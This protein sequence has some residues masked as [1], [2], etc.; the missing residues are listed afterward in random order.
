M[1]NSLNS[2]LVHADAG[3][4]S[5][6][7][8]HP[9]ALPIAV[10]STYIQPVP[11]DLAPFI[12]AE[13]AAMAAPA[14][15]EVKSFE[16]VYSRD[17]SPTT[18]RV[19]AVMGALEGAYPGSPGHA[20]AVVFSTGLAAI[21]AAMQHYAPKRIVTMLGYFGSLAGLEKYLR[22]RA[23][24]THL[25]LTPQDA[26]PA[27]L[28]AGDLVMVESPL[29]PFGDVTNLAPIA[30]RARAVGAHVVVDGTLA[31]P[32]LQYAL[33]TGIDCVIHSA[34]KYLGGHSDLLGG[35]LVTHDAATA[36]ALRVERTDIGWTMGSL[37]AWL[38]L[39]SLRTL[40]LRVRE[41]T[42]TAAVLAAWF[43]KIVACDAS[44]PNALHGTLTKVRHASLGPQP[45]WVKVQMPGG[46]SPVLAVELANR[47]A[48]RAVAHLLNVAKPA[49]SL[50]GVETLVEWR[51]Q[52][53]PSMPDGLVRISVGIEDV[54]DLK[55]DWT[56]ALVAAQKVAEGAAKARAAAA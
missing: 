40:A 49:T 15:G 17:E 8:T 14:H 38:L 36:A 54:E 55:V 3:I 23:G 7:E 43:E 33:A 11:A 12:A 19:E 2:L 50:G 1:T 45:E 56:R 51:Q 53:D 34:T 24:V 6:P 37:E 18:S 22:N 4:S 47:D 30:A 13:K 35:V 29:N 52:C 21:S 39:R 16:Y 5:H 25:A 9:V 20:H 26:L 10:S 28:G 42:K 32:P 48:A 44:V 31:P 27:D 41:Q 46:H